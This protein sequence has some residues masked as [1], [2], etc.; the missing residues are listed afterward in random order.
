MERRRSVV[1]LTPAVGGIAGAAAPDAGGGEGASGDGQC[2]NTLLLLRH[3]A[4]LMTDCRAGLLQMFS[5][6]TIHP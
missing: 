1:A 4:G 6:E 2:Q 5:F 3:R